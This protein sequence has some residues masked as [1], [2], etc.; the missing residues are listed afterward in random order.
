MTM[1]EPKREESTGLEDVGMI[2][3]AIETCYLGIDGEGCEHV[4][5]V[6]ANQVVVNDGREIDHRQPLAGR[7]LGD[8]MEHVEE[9]RGWDATG[10]F[11]AAAVSA[12][13]VRKQDGD[14]A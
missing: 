8:W 11:M 3:R 2:A 1:H 12:D 6:A 10:P 5:H 4:Y 9:A 7:P 14:C 13:E